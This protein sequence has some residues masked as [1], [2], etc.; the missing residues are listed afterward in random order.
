MMSPYFQWERVICRRRVRKLATPNTMVA[1]AKRHSMMKAEEKL[2]SRAIW[3]PMKPEPQIMAVASSPSWASLVVLLC[4]AILL[5]SVLARAGA[6]GG[7]TAF[8]TTKAGKVCQP[9]PPP[10]WLQLE[11]SVDGWSES[12]YNDSIDDKRIFLFLP[13]AGAQGKW[14]ASYG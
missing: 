12:W 2:A 8:Y 3:L 4:I 6:P 5:F 14:E 7:Q 11:K 10:G 9:L 13:Y 1:M